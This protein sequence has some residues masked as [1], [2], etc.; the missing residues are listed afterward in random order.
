M[1]L[2]HNYNHVNSSQA[3]FLF[4]DHLLE[5]DNLVRVFEQILPIYPEATILTLAYDQGKMRDIVNSHQIIASGLQH[6]IPHYK[7]WPRL[8]YFK[9]FLK[10]I[11]HL[12][13]DAKILAIQYLPLFRQTLHV[14]ELP[15]RQV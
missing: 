12:P 10:G 11:F 4:C 1:K 15:K 9:H 14:E 8:K 6:I 3:P 5:R 2:K 13:L 7:N